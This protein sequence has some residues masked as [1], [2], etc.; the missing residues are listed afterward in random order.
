MALELLHRLVP[1]ALEEDLLDSHVAQQRR[2]ESA[3]ISFGW[4]CWP[5]DVASLLDDVEALGVE[6]WP[7]MGIVWNAPEPQGEPAA[8]VTEPWR[9]TPRQQLALVSAVLGGVVIDEWDDPTTTLRL[10]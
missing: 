10:R 1:A 6:D 9:L 2:D 8:V 5:S 7:P 3:G 4:Q